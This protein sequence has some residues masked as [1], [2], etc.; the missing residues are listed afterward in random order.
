M[1]INN[2]VLLPNLQMKECLSCNCGY[3]G[4]KKFDTL[5]FKFC[6]YCRQIAIYK[7]I[8]KFTK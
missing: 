7:F 6:F 5:G 1:M 2:T 8:I 3:R 4:K